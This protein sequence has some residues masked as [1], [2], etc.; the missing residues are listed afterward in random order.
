[1]IPIRAPVDIPG[2]RFGRLTALHPTERRDAKGYVLW[3]CRCDCGNE[4]EI[5]YNNLMYTAIVSCGCRKKERST[6][7]NAHLKRVSDT[8]LDL[9]GSKKTPKNNTS[10]RKGV[11]FIR[12]K[13]LAK[14]NFQKKQYYLG[15]FDNISDAIRARRDAEDQLIEETT[16]FYE[17]WNQIAKNDP[18]WA[19]ENPVNI[20]V[21]QNDDHTFS[22]IF[23]PNL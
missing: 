8:N 11:Y 12:G 6:A 5:S 9:L 15:S 4:T 23:S 10:G 17:K 3:H 21:R 20:Q 14:I 2:R 16:Q 7:L 18:L 1:M 22:V 19:A 13:Y